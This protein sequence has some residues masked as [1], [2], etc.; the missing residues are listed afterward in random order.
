MD[1]HS[2][3]RWLGNLG[4]PVLNIIKQVQP[5]RVPRYRGFLPIPEHLKEKIEPLPPLYTQ[6][7]LNEIRQRQMEDPDAGKWWAPEIMWLPETPEQEQRLQRHTDARYRRCEQ[8]MR[9]DPEYRHQVEEY[10]RKVQEI[11]DN[12]RMSSDDL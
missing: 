10:R 7:E 12:N 11:L 5:R 2:A 4:K 1:I 9:L 6:E 3:G 8:A